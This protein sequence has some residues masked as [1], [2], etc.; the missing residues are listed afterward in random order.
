ME[1]KVE[2]SIGG[3]TLA[4]TLPATVRCFT[5]ARRMSAHPEAD[6]PKK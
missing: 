6:L 2:G 3:D 1:W 5:P 4:Q